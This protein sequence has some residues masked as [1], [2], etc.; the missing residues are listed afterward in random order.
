M[1]EID[2]KILN[3]LKTDSRLPFTE[4][5][6]VM[7]LSEGTIR[8][9]IHNLVDTQVITGFTIKTKGLKPRALVLVTILPS[10]PTSQVAERVSKVEGVETVY[11]VA[12]QMDIVLTISR[13]DIGSINQGIDEIR[14]FDGVQQ[15]N[16]LFVLREW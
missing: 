5:A 14:G 12:G 1:D 10:T 11:E 3:L 4:I 7:G 6:Q 8:R 2:A 16:T 9:R 13:K 15:T